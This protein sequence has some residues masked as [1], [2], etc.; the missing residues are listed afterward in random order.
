MFCPNCGREIPD[1]S[2]CPCSQSTAPLLST[3]P[4]VNVIKTVGS[5]T[6]YLVAAI[7]YSVS[8]VLSVVTS[9]IGSS[10]IFDYLYE[11]TGVPISALAGSSAP[12]AV[13]G[14][15]VA[16]VP[17]ILIAVGMWLH[18]TTCRRTD[19]GNISTTGLTICK[20][21]SCINLVLVSLSAVVVIGVLVL[22][23]AMSSEISYFMMNTFWFLFTSVTDLNDFAMGLA[24][25][26]LV[27]IVICTIIFT[28]VIIYYA[29]LIKTI[30]RIK[31]T[32]ITGTPDNRISRYVIVLNYILAAFALISGF[33][34]LFSAPLAGIAS[35]ASAG[36]LVLTSICMSRTRSQMTAL[37]YT[38]V[39]PV[40]AQ[41]VYTQPIA[42]ETPTDF[43]ENN[44]PEQ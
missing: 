2:V 39:Q 35:L 10:A 11:L 23:C 28:L 4:S 34:T 18:H 7:L 36:S 13:Y 20:V 26:A 40:Y 6:L 21:I 16:M 31:N 30:N 1:G 32:A 5:S 15:I 9:A 19:T 24:V 37:L 12:E 33:V 22:V 3:N 14:A 27:L 41:P 43:P 17:S 38:P 44:T 8:T 25:I 42:P 29:M